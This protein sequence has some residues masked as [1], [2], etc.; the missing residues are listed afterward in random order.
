MF[1]VSCTTTSWMV[2]SQQHSEICQILSAWIFIVTFSL[3][4][5]QL[6]LAPSARCDTCMWCFS[7][8]IF[9]C[10]SKNK[11]SVNSDYFSELTNVPISFSPSGGCMR[12][13]WQGLYHHLWAIWRVLRGWSCRRMRW[14]VQFH[15]LSGTSKHCSSCMSLVLKFRDDFSWMVK[16]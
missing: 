14:M 8:K 6:H 3:E 5:Y 13:T 16:M 4:P 7:Y 11:T 10:C 12:T 2:Q 15:H 9:I 1:A